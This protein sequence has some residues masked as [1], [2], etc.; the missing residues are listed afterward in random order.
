VWLFPQPVTKVIMRAIPY[1]LALLIP[2]ISLSW[3]AG[4]KFGAFAA[5]R[6]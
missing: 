1:T 3:I 2:A 6:K 4:N 5:R